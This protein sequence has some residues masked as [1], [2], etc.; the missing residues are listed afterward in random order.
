VEAVQNPQIGFTVIPVGKTCFGIDLLNAQP[1]GA[2]SAAAVAHEVVVEA[3]SIDDACEQ[4]GEIVCAR[5]RRSDGRLD[6]EAC[7][8][9][10]LQG[11][12]PSGDRRRFR[13]EQ[14]ADVVSV[15][16]DGDGD[17]DA[18]FEL[19]EQVDVSGDER[20]SRLDKQEVGLLDRHRFKQRPGDFF[21]RFDRL[22][23]VGAGGHEEGDRA[24]FPGGEQLF[25]Q[26]LSRLGLDGDP[27][28]PF[29]FAKKSHGHLAH[30]AVGAGIGAAGI[31][32]ERVAVS[33]EK[34]RGRVEEFARIFS[35]DRCFHTILQHYKSVFLSTMTPRKQ[36][37]SANLAK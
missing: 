17:A 15:G 16:F 19:L 7:F 37:T 32:V 27:R 29:L 12:E 18:V 23:R 5:Q 9:E 11:F 28:P 6:G 24:F 4:A 36:N 31:R 10:G 34:P 13:C 26:H 20:T 22:V 35:G 25:F 14:L 30:V 3:D 8:G 33:G 2:L 1:L 21:L